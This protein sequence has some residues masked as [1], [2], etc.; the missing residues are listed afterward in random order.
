MNSNRM[1]LV[2]VV[3]YGEGDQKKSRRTNIGV[4]LQNRDVMPSYDLCRANET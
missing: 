4:A 3:Q 1:K 2:A